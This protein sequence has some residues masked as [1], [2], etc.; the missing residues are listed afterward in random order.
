VAQADD[1]LE[2]ALLD[3]A[4][5]VSLTTASMAEIDARYGGEPGAGAPPRPEEFAPPDGAFLLARVDGRPAGCG[6]LCRQDDEVA[7][8]RRMYVV[9]EARGRGLGREIL[10]GLMEAARDLGYRRV[11]LETGNRQHEAMG[12]YR[13]AGFE[14]IPCWGPYASDPK[15]ICLELKLA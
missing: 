7:E 10:T 12:L 4:E 1:M 14:R 3:D 9:P 15:S 8:I 6:G 13:A 5:A 11:R 2:K